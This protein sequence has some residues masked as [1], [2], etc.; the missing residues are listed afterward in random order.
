MLSEIV[1]DDQHVAA[2]FHEILRD[3][4]RG[5]RCDVSE[6]GRFVTAAHHDNGIFKRIFLAQDCDRLGD[7]RGALTDRAIHA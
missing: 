6:T 5:V 3:T 2:G 4:G 1:V 7:R